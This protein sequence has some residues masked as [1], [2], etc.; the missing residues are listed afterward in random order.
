TR[1]TTRATPAS[2]LATDARQTG[3]RWNERLF[4]REPIVALAI[5]EPVEVRRQ[6]RPRHV[7][8]RHA[9]E[10]AGEV[11]RAGRRGFIREDAG[12]EE[13]GQPGPL[14][15]ARAIREAQTLEIH[16]DAQLDAARG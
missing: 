9:D 11:G 15:R 5:L 1:N 10:R 12:V 2:R 14:G 13:L 6:R 4:R 3:E 7:L 8:A 16:V